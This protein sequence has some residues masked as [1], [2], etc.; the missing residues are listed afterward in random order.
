MNLQ[1]K[2]LGGIQDFDQNR[3]TRGVVSF[4]ENLTAVVSPDFVQRSPA[5]FRLGDDALC[6]FAVD[7][8][9]RF[10]NPIFARECAVEISFAVCARPKFVPC[11]MVQMSGIRLAYACVKIAKG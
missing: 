9:P 7:Q 4:A 10:A 2:S 5:K 8:F 1:R 11:T 6:I 3:K